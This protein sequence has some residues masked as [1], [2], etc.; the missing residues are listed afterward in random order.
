MWSLKKRVKMNLFAEEKQTHK[1]LKTYGYQRGQVQGVGGMD[2]GFRIG[3]CT[4]RYMEIWN[5]WPKGTCYIEHREL[6]P[7]L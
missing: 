7:I 3:I 6:Y 4:L 2:W 5:N 1:L